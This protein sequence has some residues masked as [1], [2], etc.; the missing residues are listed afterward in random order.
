MPPVRPIATLAAMLLVFLFAWILLAD[1]LPLWSDEISNFGQ[2]KA[3][4]LTGTFKSFDFDKN[5]VLSGEIEAR[6]LL[7]DRMVSFFLSIK[8]SGA[9][10]IMWGRLVPLLFTLLT[11][12]LVFLYGFFRFDLSWGTLLYLSAFFLGQSMVME[13]ALFVRIYAP[14]MFCMVSAFICYWE[15]KQFF[16]KD[17]KTI[18]TG[19]FL[20]GAAWVWVTIADHWQFEQI[21]VVVLGIVLSFRKVFES[22]VRFLS[23]K[24]MQFFLLC[25]ALVL[26]TPFVVI[27]IDEILSKMVIGNMLIGVTFMTF[28]DNAMGLLRAGLALNICLIGIGVAVVKGKDKIHFTFGWWLFFTGIISV[29]LGGLL[30]PHNY[31]FFTRY[32]LTPVAFT[33]IGFAFHFKEIFPS[34][35]QRKALIICYLL[36]NAFLSFSTFYWDRPNNRDAVSW[37]KNN[38]GHHEVLLTFDASVGLYGGEPLI[39]QAYPIQQVG[40]EMLKA[41][42][43]LS[44][45]Q[46]HPGTKVYYLFV[47]GYSFR[48]KLY[49]WTTGDDRTGLYELHAYIDRRIPHQTPL[50]N[51]RG[52]LG[53]DIFDQKTLEKSLEELIKTGYPM[54]DRENNISIHKQIL[55]HIFRF[56]HLPDKREDFRKLE[57]L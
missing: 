15:G 6:D 22:L 26:F 50:Q 44:F 54:R 37:L 20:A 53:I 57:P 29:V 30:N 10:E 12:L 17:R 3:F 2:S 39:P 32:S 13:E 46:Q 42:A 31:V 19:L 23:V 27:L 43:L 14:L 4:Y 55:K 36:I 21:P 51:L 48:D 52:G 25:L 18:G 38:M 24:K 7:M 34:S 45:L 5:Q 56:F 28:W 16:L 11:F 33:L 47:D 35:A 9:P 49:H 40:D 1:Y 8:P 41:K